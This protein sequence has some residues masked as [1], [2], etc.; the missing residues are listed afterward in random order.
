[1][2]IIS[3][4]DIMK[5]VRSVQRVMALLWLNTFDVGDGSGFRFILVPC[6]CTTPLMFSIRTT[7]MTIHILSALTA[8]WPPSRRVDALFV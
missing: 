4:F 6:T 7:S 2:G 8:P 3:T 1:M 5:K